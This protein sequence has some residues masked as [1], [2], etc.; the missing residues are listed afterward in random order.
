VRSRSLRFLRSRSRF[1]KIPALAL[2]E[3]NLALS[4]ALILEIAK[5]LE[6]VQKRDI[7]VFFAILRVPTNLLEQLVEQENL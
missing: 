5:F 3:E 2:A 1:L 6:N 4:L 7:E